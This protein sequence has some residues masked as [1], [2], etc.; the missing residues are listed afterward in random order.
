MQKEGKQYRKRRLTIYRY[1][2]RV[3][4]KTCPSHPITDSRHV[5]GNNVTLFVM[6]VYNLGLEIDKEV[7]QFN[8][9][10]KH[11]EQC[12]Q[13]SQPTAMKLS[14]KL[15]LQRHPGRLQ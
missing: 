8:P 5:D 1:T 11:I 15:F 7:L 14:K 4:K 13:Q 12:P 10:T 6:I 9:Y 3:K 2:N